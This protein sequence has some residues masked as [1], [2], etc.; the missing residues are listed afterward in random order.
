[1]L[2]FKYSILCLILKPISKC[3]LSKNVHIE[4]PF[5]KIHGFWNNVVLKL[6]QIPRKLIVLSEKVPKK[7]KFFVLGRNS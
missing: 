3:F 7:I 1:M 6:Y 4:L 2:S 5:S